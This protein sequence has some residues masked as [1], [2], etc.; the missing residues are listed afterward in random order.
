MFVSERCPSYRESTKRSKERQGPTLGV[1]FSEVSIKRESIVFIFKIKGYHMHI[2]LNYPVAL[3]ANAE[4]L[5]K[6]A[7]T[8]MIQYSKEVGWRA[9]CMLHSPIIPRW[10]TTCRAK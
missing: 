7:L 8:S 5:D 9:Y 4:L 3:E 2:L 6:R 10:R 1:H